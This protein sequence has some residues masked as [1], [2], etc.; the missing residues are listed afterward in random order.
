MKEVVIIGGGPVGLTLAN[1][2]SETFKV[3]VITPKLPLKFQSTPESQ[4]KLSPNSTSGTLF[5][6]SKLWGSQHEGL[7]N[8]VATAPIFSDLPGFS[9][10]LK[11]LEKFEE[12]LLRQGWPKLRQYQIS[13]DT[14]F[15]GM[16]SST[17]WKGKSL[18]PLPKKLSRNI[19]LISA[20]VEK[21]DFTLNSSLK[22][23]SIT[24][25]ETEF[26]AD[27]FVFAAG[28][29]G[30]IALLQKLFRESHP[31]GDVKLKMLGV[32]Y[33]NHPK[34]SLLRIRFQRPKYFGGFSSFRKYKRMKNWD[35]TGTHLEPRQLRVS[36]RLWPMYDDSTWFSKIASRLLR[37]FGFYVEAQLVV[38]IELPQISQNFVQLEMQKNRELN[39]Y[40]NYS[41]PANMEKFLQADLQNIE[42]CISSNQNLKII[43]REELSLQHILLQDGNHHFGGTRMA[44]NSEQGVVDTFSRCFEISNL[45][46]LGTSTLPISTYLHPTFLCAA[47]ALRAAEEIK[48]NG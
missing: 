19:K 21:I 41:F 39:F 13:P 26:K 43:K 11:E 4:F 35:L 16:N 44:N 23:K 27:V 42:R 31:Q 30:N 2:L 6:N 37:I 29:L 33:S 18:K 48:R 36:T 9:F 24:I 8:T 20:E 40:F 1:D 34:T 3:T 7:E 38:Y 14:T 22:L 12:K 47:L 5:G 25:D 10:D 46:I 15:T 32:G 28:G 17:Y 45:F